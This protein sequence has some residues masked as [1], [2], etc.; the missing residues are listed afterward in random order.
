MVLKHFDGESSF[1]FDTKLSRQNLQEHCRIQNANVPSTN[2][3]SVLRRA[4]YLGRYVLRDTDMLTESNAV[5][6]L[7]A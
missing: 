6:V 4:A 3:H 2:S 1:H 5:Q 7:G